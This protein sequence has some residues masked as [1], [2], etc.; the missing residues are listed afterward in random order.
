MFNPTSSNVSGNGYSN[1]TAHDP[2]SRIF[3]GISS[4]AGLFT[5]SEDLFKLSD[6]LFQGKY[7]NESHI[8]RLYE[9]NIIGA[10]RGDMGLYLK[11][12]DSHAVTY[13][14][15]ELSVA[16]FTAQGYTGS[17]AT[18]DLK[19]KIHNNILV[20][21]IIDD[22][23]NSLNDKP[24]EFLDSFDSYQIELFKSIMLMYVI[25]TYYNKYLNV[26]EDYILRRKI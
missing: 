6:I 4:H 8:K 20:N 3:G 23:E 21:A 1:N 17:T 22:K 7:L 12:F 18:F 15:D 11:H 19:N 9:K 14:P 26:K 25:K 2:K 16:S 24:L 10:S 5:N 13:N